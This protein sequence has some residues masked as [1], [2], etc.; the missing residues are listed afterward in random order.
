M[1]L[2]VFLV[3]FSL[4]LSA[5]LRNDE[6][7]P[8]FSKRPYSVLKKGVQ[9]WMYSID[10]QWTSAKKTIPERAIS[11]NEKFYKSKEHKLGSDNFEEFRIYP[12][13]YGK[14]TLVLLVKIFS[15]GYFKYE[16]SK[17]G[18][19]KTSNVSYYLFNKNALDVL[20]N[21]KDSTVQTISID[22][23]DAGTIRNIKK[24]N[25]MKAIQRK[26]AINEDFDREFIA[27]IQPFT[28]MDRIRF[29]FFSLHK[30]FRDVEGVRKDFTINGQS[31]YLD[32]RLFDYLYYETEIE[33]FSEFIR[34][35]PRF[36][37]KT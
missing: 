34:L 3:L 4:Q 35:P 12:T 1:R 16:F 23:L 5:Q 26:V 36:E 9:G 18:W 27:M 30:V 10:D 8:Q 14:D 29:Q 15:D 28:V 2:T 31:M 24:S 25:V 33:N 32:D 37:F 6:P 17:K 7:L 11:T 22:L 13:L 21:L 19:K 20:D